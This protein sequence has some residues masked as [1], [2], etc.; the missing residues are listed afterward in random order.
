MPKMRQRGWVPSHGDERNLAVLRKA[1]LGVSSKQ[2]F[3][4]IHFCPFSPFL[5]EKK[6]YSGWLRAPS[7][8]RV[9]RRW[10]FNA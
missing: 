4:Q 7:I 5:C 10:I 2:L 3:K 6:L 8:A 9:M 1:A